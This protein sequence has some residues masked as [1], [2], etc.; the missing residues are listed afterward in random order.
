LTYDIDIEHMG[1]KN[2]IKV[3]GKN[4]VFLAVVYLIIGIVEFAVAYVLNAFI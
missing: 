3:I 1:L 4:L 2:L